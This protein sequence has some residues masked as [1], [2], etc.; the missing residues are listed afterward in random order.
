MRILVTGAAGQLGREL[1]RLAARKAPHNDY[2]F[3]DAAQLDICDRDAVRRAVAGLHPGAIVNCA[4]YT[5]VERAESEPDAADR[6]NRLAA[7]YLAEAAE[8]TGATLFHISTDYVFDGRQ[9]RPYDEQA[10]TAPL[11]VY[12]RTKRAGER[13]VAESGCRHLIF[14]TA[15]LYSE[16]G[17]NFLKTMLRLTAE[18]D[19]LQV[20]CDQTGTPT[21][22]ADLARAIFDRIESG[23][24]REAQGI[25][26]FSDEGACSWYD[27]AVEI[28]AAAGRDRCRIVPC[29]TEEY[30][31]RAERPAYSVLDK[32]KIRN[33]FRIAIPHWRQSMLECLKR[34]EP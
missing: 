8:A 1:Q 7:G 21:W 28:A 14:R 10:P 33:A 12:G 22:A 9:C 20:V 5:D 34:M 16:H 13:A 24:Y 27:F 17:R 31:T 3:T 2:V 19:R 26:H 32:T 4:A 18:R 25:Y 30:P 15:W 11:G 6:V 23:D 29:R